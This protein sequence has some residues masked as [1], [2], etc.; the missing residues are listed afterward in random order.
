MKNPNSFIYF[1]IGIVLF[2][3]AI[4]QDYNILIPIGCFFI[5]LGLIDMQ[6]DKED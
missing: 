6:K 4:F 5:I 2:I 1:I 3:V